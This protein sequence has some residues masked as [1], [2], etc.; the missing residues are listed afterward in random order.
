MDGMSLV[1]L[2][3]GGNTAP[4]DLFWHYPHYG[5]QGGEPSTIIRSGDWKLIHYWEDGRDELYNPSQDVGERSDLS[6]EKPE[7]R[8]AL[9]KKLDKWIVEVG[10]KL[11]QLNPG[12]DD[13]LAERQRNDM[14][15]KRL[16][17][18]EKQHANFLSPDF[19]PNATWWDSVPD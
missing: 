12:Y 16:P 19:K 1:P 17:K 14:R 15:T 6:S 10:A 13:K 7:I 9:R 5:N 2:L 11:P 3:K 4:R 8:A 18:L